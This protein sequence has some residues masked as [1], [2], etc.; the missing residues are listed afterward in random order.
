MVKHWLETRHL[1]RPVDHEHINYVRISAENIVKLNA[2]RQRLLGT[3][4]SLYEQNLIDEESAIA[5]V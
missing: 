3:N 1:D 2:L 5:V 4:R